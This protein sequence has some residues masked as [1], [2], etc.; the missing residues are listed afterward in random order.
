MP[1]IPSIYSAELE[2]ERAEAFGQ[3]VDYATDRAIALFSSQVM[4]AAAAGIKKVRDAAYAAG[5]QAGADAAMAAIART[6]RQVVR[7]KPRP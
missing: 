2:A 5:A 1:K 3:G 6:T 7:E 4:P